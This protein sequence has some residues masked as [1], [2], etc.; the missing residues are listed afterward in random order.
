[1]KKNILFIAPF[2]FLF[3]W[4]ILRAVWGIEPTHFSEIS[5]ATLALLLGLLFVKMN[6]ILQNTLDRERRGLDREMRMYDKIEAY[7]KQGK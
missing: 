3:V 5:L 1:M 7:L 4:H 2:V 6:S